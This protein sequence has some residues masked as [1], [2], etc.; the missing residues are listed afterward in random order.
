MT[1]LQRWERK[2]E[3]LLERSCLPCL[4]YT[5]T[6]AYPHD[7]TAFTQGLFLHAGFL[8]ESTG[9]W[10][11]SSVRKVRLADGAILERAPLPGIHFGEGLA[12]WGDQLVSL[13]WRDR[14]GYRWSLTDL[15]PLGTFT[16]PAE[17]WGMTQNGEHLIVSDGSP[18]I[19]FLDPLTLEVSRTIRVRAGESD[20]SHCNDLEWVNNELWANVFETGLIARIDPRSGS[21][22]GWLD[23]FPFCLEWGTTLQSVLNGLAYE[24]A[25]GRLLVTGKNWP[26][27]LELTFDHTAMCAAP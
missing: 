2:S 1:H 8:Y 18:V 15:R 13:T 26:L 5:I 9:W 10:G 16:Y 17:A 20:L 14:V 27:L 19:R 4:S 25:T 7:P 3:A 22:L 24:V 11:R 23:L 12:A 6:G 21:V